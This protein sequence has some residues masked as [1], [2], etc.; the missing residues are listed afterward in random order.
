MD[1]TCGTSF[2]S[3]SEPRDVAYHRM[4]KAKADLPPPGSYR[5]GPTLYQSKQGY[6]HKFGDAKTATTSR[7]NEAAAA[8]IGEKGQ[9]GPPPGTYDVSA[10]T[11][12]G[13]S[14]SLPGVTFR[15]R[16]EPTSRRQISPDRNRPRSRARGA[17]KGVTDIGRTAQFRKEGG[18]SKVEKMEEARRRMEVERDERERQVELQSRRERQQ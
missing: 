4:I 13:R 14:G 7:S 18:F 6:P 16:G 12:A 15:P 3:R 10:H 2:H 5:L 1:S 8:R 17:V 11:I 9:Q